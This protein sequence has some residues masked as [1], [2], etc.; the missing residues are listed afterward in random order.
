MKGLQNN[1]LAAVAAGSALLLTI[2]GVGG[3]VAANT[4]G[5]KD[6]RNGSVRSADLRDGAV[7]R[8]DV[9]RNL[10]DIEASRMT[11]LPS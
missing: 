8:A 9:G 10:A 6:I 11:P 7:K 2:G 5:S 1:R 4:I 3:A